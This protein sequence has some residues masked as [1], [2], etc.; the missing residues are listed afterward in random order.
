MKFPRIVWAL[1]CVAVAACGSVAD[2]GAVDGEV[3][4]AH[5]GSARPAGD[6]G[7]AAP[8]AGGTPGDDAGS[9]P[10]IDAGD[11]PRFDAGDTPTLDA[12]PG[13][14]FDAGA[15]AMRDAGLVGHDAGGIA[16][17]APPGAVDVSAGGSFHAAWETRP[18]A[19]FFAPSCAFG[20]PPS[21]LHRAAFVLEL[22]GT[23]DV[24]VLPTGGDVQYVRLVWGCDAGAGSAAECA[25]TGA[26]WAPW[27]ANFRALPAGTYL[28]LAE[29]ST[30]MPPSGDAS[31]DVTL[32]PSP[33]P[34]PNDD[35]AGA[36]DLG[37]GGTVAGT[38]RGA[39]VGASGLPD[40]FYRFT[41]TTSSDVALAVDGTQTVLLATDCAAIGATTVVSASRWGRWLHAPGLP[42]GT[43]YVAVGWP[44]YADIA[45]DAWGFALDATIRAPA[46][47]GVG[48]TCAAPAALA[49]PATVTDDFLGA[50]NST[51][52]PATPYAGTICSSFENDGDADRFYAVHVATAGTNLDVTA[53]RRVHLS[54]ATD[55]ADFRGTTVACAH[56]PLTGTS[57]SLA[58]RS[59]A[60]GDYVLRVQ[61][62]ADATMPPGP[63]TLS[64]G[65]H[66]PDETCLTPAG[67]LTG[68][69][70]T[71]LTGSTAASFDDHRG[72]CGSTATVGNDVVW[73]LDLTVRSR[74]VIDASTS[75]GVVVY[76]RRACA[77]ASSQVL[78]TSGT[79]ATT[80]DP[81]RYFIVVDGNV[82][83]GG[84]YS[85]WV[86]RVA[87]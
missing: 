62:A 80:L 76:L 16:C 11:T 12:G 55:C 13:A 48:D 51:R 15:S 52:T 81:G 32:T 43:Y 66:T 72:S 42:A 9:A 63:L 25:Y 56:A 45:D 23:T 27:A 39:T 31:V 71:T 73:T 5:D 44:T 69:G 20:P 1:A 8:D 53:D 17:S 10:G 84:A 41:T 57:S 54:L 29:Q 79:S 64:V 7:G 46:V 3:G 78:C 2:R 26:S 33:P 70:A 61:W 14:G 58:A 65:E 40:V 37:A 50:D 74:V 35:C 75:P 21:E 28:L 24:R 22:G 4:S 49:L 68:E 82:R 60:A 30:P 67:A 77:D 86:D 85:V 47:A 18:D 83:G 38:F 59:L 34:P 19:G 36:I 6:G 87:L